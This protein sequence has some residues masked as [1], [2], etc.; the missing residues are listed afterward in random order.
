MNVLS[1]YHFFSCVSLFW[2]GLVFGFFG[3]TQ[4]IWKIP[5]QGSNL[6]CG[7][8]LCHSC[9]NTRSLKSTVPQQQ[10]LYHFLKV[11]L[12]RAC[13]FCNDKKS[14]LFSKYIWYQRHV[15]TFFFFLGPH[16]QHVKV[17]RL[18]VDLEL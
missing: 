1:F 12:K 11:S 6:S 15:E 18:G 14:Y 9:S 7:C 2:F 3:C 8:N 4:S 5:G 13:I 16:L 10:L 17:P